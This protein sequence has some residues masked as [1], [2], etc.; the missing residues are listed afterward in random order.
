MLCYNAAAHYWYSKG[1]LAD[2]LY[3][4]EI[5]HLDRAR[6][7]LD[8]A[9]K[10]EGSLLRNLADNRGK[11]LQ[12][13][14]QRL[15]AALKDND[16]IYMSTVPRPDTVKD[17]EAVVTVKLTPFTAPD[18]VDP[19]AGLLSPLVRQ[20]SDEFRTKLKEAMAK[21]E[22][23]AQESGDYSKATLSSLGLPA[24][25]E[26]EEGEQGLSD[27]LWGQVSAVQ[28]KGGRDSLEAQIERIDISVR[29]AKSA[30]QSIVE[31]LSKEKAED[32]SMRQQFG[33]R[34]NRRPSEQ[35]TAQFSRDVDI[36]RKYLQ[37]ADKSNA[38]VKAELERNAAALD[39]L[40]QPRQQID[41]RL[42]HNTQVAAQSSQ[43]KR[44]AGDRLHTLLDALSALID[45]RAQ[46]LVEAQAAAAKHD[47]VP[48][49]NAQAGRGKSIEAIW[50]EELAQYDVYRQR[51]TELHGRQ[52]GLLHDLKSTMDV[53]ESSSRQ[54]T[55]TTVTQ[56]QSVLQEL[57]DGIRTFDRLL[58]N[59]NEGAKFYSDLQA[60][61]IQPLR[62]RVE[63]FAMARRMESQMVLS[64]LT[65][66]IASYRDEPSG[67]RSSFGSPKGG[68]GGASAG[69]HPINPNLA[70]EHPDQPMYD[71]APPPPQPVSR[72]A[73]PPSNPFAEYTANPAAGG[74]HQQQQ[75][76]PQSQYG[77][78]QAQ[79]GGAAAAATRY[80]PSQ[81]AAGGY[82]QQQAGYHQRQ[83]SQPDPYAGAPTNAY[84]PASSYPGQYQPAPYA[85]A[86]RAAAARAPD[87][88]GIACPSCTYIN[89]L[90][91]VKC[92][93]CGNSVSSGAAGGTGAVPMPQPSGFLR[94]FNPR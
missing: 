34:W 36:V 10:V 47:I 39:A 65:Q 43:V 84:Q 82:Q 29:E 6:A 51:M 70:Y 15:T 56:R 1:L 7:L 93:I 14:Q 59:L 48:V 42:P 45:E 62:Q 20:Q 19:Y 63:D 49:I 50:G 9:S 17:P 53:Y 22:R 3:G 77:G 79:Q 91:S 52:E 60:Q 92:E 38:K 73:T 64:Q 81:P 31:E 32:D 12:A 40:M 67:Q 90:G 11:L 44:E 94:Q 24:A 4:E 35:L 72:Q 46:V 83:P 75:Q 85:P 30:V 66:D 33:S 18:A 69:P 37:E 80:T 86:P 27:D 89:P 55:T 68:A 26:A 71:F 76:P 25:L 54:K 28:Y 88:P 61:R 78:Y 21:M 23:E 2:D 5:A 41:A 16:T 8:A 57:N 13:I 74:Y 87:P 58:A